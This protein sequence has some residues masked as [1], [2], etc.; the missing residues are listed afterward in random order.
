[1]SN[2]FLCNQWFRAFY[3]RLYV[4]HTLLRSCDSRT[5]FISVT[6]VLRAMR[7]TQLALFRTRIITFAH[8]RARKNLRLGRESMKF[9]ANTPVNSKLFLPRVNQVECC[10]GDIYMNSYNPINA[11]RSFIV[12]RRKCSVYDTIC[13]ILFD[14]D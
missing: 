11:A 4:G 6:N 13:A 12:S 8:R 3:G 9:I 14:N 2:K 7:H 5:C 1:M 10:I